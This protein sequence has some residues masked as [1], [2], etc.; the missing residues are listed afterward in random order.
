M[1]K[2]EIESEQFR[3]SEIKTTGRNL[4][5]EDTPPPFNQNNKPLSEI[6]SLFDEFE[7]AD[8]E[9]I[10]EYELCIPASSSSPPT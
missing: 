8:Y 4:K 10:D 5:E 9:P 6:G 1:F 7:M 2:L 3:N